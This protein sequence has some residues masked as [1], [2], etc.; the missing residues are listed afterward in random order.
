[1]IAQG[2]MAN[3]RLEKEIDPSNL[4]RLSAILAKAILEE[5]NK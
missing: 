2:F 4:G 5:A 1:M 3:S